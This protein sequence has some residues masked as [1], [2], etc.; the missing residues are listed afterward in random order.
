MKVHGPMSGISEPA[1]RDFWREGMLPKER[2]MRRWQSS[3]TD[4]QAQELQGPTLP[5]LPHQPTLWRALWS[6]SVISDPLGGITPS[7]SLFCCFA[8]FQL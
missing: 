8:S 5:L 7:R 1:V 2:Q 3:T 6:V 4:D